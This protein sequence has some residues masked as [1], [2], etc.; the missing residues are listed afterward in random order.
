[1]T[2]SQGIKDTIRLAVRDEDYLVDAGYV[3]GARLIESGF[4]VE[5]FFATRDALASAVVEAPYGD[6]GVFIATKG[7]HAGCGI[8]MKTG[9]FRHTARKPQKT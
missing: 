2:L 9:E 3:V 6:V 8:D 1:M 4:G 7:L 5:T